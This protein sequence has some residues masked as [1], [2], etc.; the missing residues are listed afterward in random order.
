MCIIL[1]VLM[2]SILT[3]GINTS[4]GFDTTLLLNHSLKPLTECTLNVLFYNFSAVYRKYIIIY[5]SCT[6]RGNFQ[7]VDVYNNATL[8]SLTD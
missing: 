6:P 3:L 1:S 7:Y 5:K 4:W 2:T 8:N